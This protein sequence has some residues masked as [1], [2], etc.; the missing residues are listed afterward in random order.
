[1]KERHKKESAHKSVDLDIEICSS[2]PSASGSKPRKSARKEEK[3]VIIKTIDEELKDRNKEI[4]DL[5]SPI[6]TLSSR[7]SMHSFPAP[8]Y[9][10]ASTSSLSRTFSP[11]EKGHVGSFNKNSENTP[12]PFIHPSASSSTR[13]M[14][15][16]EVLIAEYMSK[17]EVLIAK[18]DTEL[19]EL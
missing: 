19:E 9:S 17:T 7:A 4:D 5:I 2:F 1:F 14:S 3:K 18:D 10:S 15:K 8:T 11:I 6:T 13:Y 12:K 16:T